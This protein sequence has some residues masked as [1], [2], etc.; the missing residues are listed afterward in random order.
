MKTLIGYTGFIGSSLLDQTKFDLKYNSQNIINISKKKHDLII[1]A[2]APG[3]KWIANKYS[4]K[5]FLII[6]KLIIQLKKIKCNKFILISTIDVFN[7]PFNVT[8]LTKIRKI[9]KKNYGSNRYYLEEN[10]KKIFKNYIIIRLPGIVGDK[11]KKN[12]LYDFKYNNDLNKID[13]RNR[14]QF[15]PIKYLWNDIKI[16]IKNEL[17]LVHFTSEPISISELYNKVYKKKFK[18]ILSQQP[19]NY[20]MISIHAKLFSTSKNKKYLYEKKDILK[21]IKKYLLNK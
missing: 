1:C 6:K 5:D 4:K 11:L 17:K 19:V 8:E 15:Y 2:A 21:I 3:F 20:N 16:S 10:V 12:A 9:K 13:S 14:Y 18:N 7:T